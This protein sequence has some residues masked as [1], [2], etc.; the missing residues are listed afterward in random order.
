MLLGEYIRQ[1]AI[2]KGSSL[3]RVL[4]SAGISERVY[5]NAIQGKSFFG[6]DALD[7]IINALAPAPDTPLDDKK[8]VQ[9]YRLYMRERMKTEEASTG[10]SKLVTDT[11]LMTYAIATDDLVEQVL[12]AQKAEE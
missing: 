6:K 1:L 7:R 4:A 5:Y 8:Q 9:I 10:T 2:E 3:A 12:D 11:Y